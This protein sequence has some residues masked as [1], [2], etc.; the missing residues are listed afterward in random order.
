MLGL[1]VRTIQYRLREYNAQGAAPRAAPCH[2]GARRAV[3]E[4]FAHPRARGR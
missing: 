1:S 4:N 2:N 3:L